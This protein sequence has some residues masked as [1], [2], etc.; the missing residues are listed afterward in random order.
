M[1]KT[2]KSVYNLIA[3]L[4]QVCTIQIITLVVSRKVLSVYGSEINGVNAIFTN[5]LVWLMLLEGGFT[6]ASSVALFK[7]F[8]NKDLNYANRILSATKKALNKI[9]L[10]AAIGGV[11][12]AFVA[13]LFIK[14][15]LS[16]DL[17]LSMFLL[18]VFGTYFGLAFTRKYALMFSVKQE[19]FLK[20]YISVFV[21][22][23][24]NAIIYVVATKGIYYVWVRVIVAFGVILTGILT[25]LIVKMRYPYVS[26]REEPDM[27]AIIGTKDMVFNKLASLVSTSTP[28][29]YI[30]STIGAASASVYA[31]YMIIFGFVMKLNT[32]VANAVQS[33][34]GQMI[35]EKTSNEVYLK[36][37]TFEFSVILTAFI[38]ISIAT[39]VTIPFIKFYTKN[40]SD[41]NYI[42]SVYLYLFVG[43][44]LVKVIHIPSGIVM[45]MSGAFKKSKTFQIKGLLI[46]ITGIVTGG[47]FK[48]IAGVLCG[49]LIAAIVLGF[50][51]IIYTRKEYF[52]RGFKDIIKTLTILGIATSF[53]ILTELK[54]VP[55]ELNFDEII[56]YTVFLSVINILVLLVIAYVFF[57]DIVM[58][59]V[60]IVKSILTRTKY[61]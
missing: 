61:V 21:S 41:I 37:R 58:S 16:Y 36:F 59:V 54:Y 25:W 45:L 44:T 53:V 28:L 4:V 51:E 17:M 26:Y 27:K 42:N 39:P 60:L 47:Y 5:T 33:G 52:N 46:L 19:E 55:K 56:S 48:G 14:T 23:I 22:I 6:F 49:I 43:I 29:I 24:T 7:A 3:A 34:F 15:S 11:I 32:M 20:I 40:V 18:M 13:P 31:V 35:A 12:L 57:N 8:A 38:L 50:Q 10:L 1:S 2:K 30:A 9:G